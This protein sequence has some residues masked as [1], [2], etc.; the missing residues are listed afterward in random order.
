MARVRNTF[1]KKQI[2]KL[3]QSEN[4]PVVFKQYI[5]FNITGG[6]TGYGFRDNSGTIQFKNESG[7]WTNIGGG[8]G[9]GAV[10]SVNGQ[11]GVVVL[12][13]DDIDD[14]STTN[15]FVT[16]SDITKLGHISVTQAVD[17]DQMETDI[18]AL[19]NGMVYK[20]DW[21]ASA[22]TFPGAGVAQ[23]GWFYYVT[24]AG[25]VG[26]VEFVIGDNIVAT[27]DNASTTV[28]A[29]NWSKHDQTDAVQSV[30]GLTGSISKSSLLTALNV[31]DGAEVNNISDTNAT[32]LTDGEETTL[33]AHA[34]S[35]VTGL[36]T[37]L[38]S[39]V[40]STKSADQDYAGYDIRDVG[41]AGFKVNAIGNSS[42]SFN[43]DWNGGAY[44]SLT[45]TGD[46]SVGTQTAP[47]GDSANGWRLQLD[48]IQD[49]TGG[50]DFTPPSNWVFPD[51]EPTWTAGTAN[52]RIIITAMYNGTNYVCTA[53]SWFTNP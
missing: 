20:G 36:Q 23:T 25:T 28:Y 12:N 10:D 22:G 30:V 13:A 14:T 21:D 46:A 6:E 1:W 24:V 18:A 52:Q 29:S 27:V 33:H 53:T 44:Q 5:N 2:D 9:G 7:S 51:G 48:V 8:G 19:A 39:K 38:D 34:I 16:A 3:V 37:A 40:G 43:L 47:S 49:G 42:T 15:K 35:S 41:L 32:D 26:G 11:T 4:I 17:L 45:L 50:R 31:E